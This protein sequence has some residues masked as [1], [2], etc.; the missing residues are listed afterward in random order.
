MSKRK[1]VPTTTGTHKNKL[2]MKG[3]GKARPSSKK[4][5][6]KKPIYCDES[7]TSSP[8]PAPIGNTTGGGNTAVNYDDDDAFTDSSGLDALPFSEFDATSNR[9]QSSNTDSNTALAWAIPL[10]ILMALAAVIAA[11]WFR[12]HHRRCHF[13]ERGN[14]NNKSS[15]I[16]AATRTAMGK[17]DNEDSYSSTTKNN[18]LDGDATDDSDASTVSC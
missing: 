13:C 8:F 4:G 3:K 5:S 12:Y 18:A 10:V 1:T 17:F 15:M 9:S 11:Y 14:S 6:K 7:P 2:G 16:G